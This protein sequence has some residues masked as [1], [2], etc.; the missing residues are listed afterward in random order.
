VRVLF[1]TTANDGHFGPLVPLARAFASAGHDV[2]VAAPKS[3]EAT[4]TRAGLTHRPFADAPPE[5]IGPVMARLPT[6][7]FHEADN[8]V[9][10][11]VFGRID[12]QAALPGVTAAIEE[13][14][15]DLLLREPA[16]FGSLAAAERAG[17]PHLQVAVGMAEVG[18]LIAASVAEPLAELGALAGVH[19]GSLA[20]AALAEPTLTSVPE[21]LD[22]AGDD[23]DP[24]SAL[25]RF[26]DESPPVTTE[27]LPEWGD[28]AAP[29]VYVTFGSVAGSLPP[30]SGSYRAAL[31]A[32]ADLPIRV[33]MTLGRR[34]DPA[35]LGP[36]ARNARA[37]AWW[38][39]SA[40]LAQA[41]A[42][43][44]HGGFGTTMGALAA[45]LP[46]V[47][48]PLFTFDQRINARHVAAVGAGMGFEPGPTAIADA[49]AALLPLLAEPWYTVRA[50]AVAASIAQ[51]PP[52]AAA[53]D[54]ALNFIA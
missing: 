30:F 33:F 54:A 52:P 5:L 28:P 40:V 29:L 37:V 11:E 41:S 12:A 39:Q 14:R 21:D 4:V 7:S 31:E 46:Q 19:D 2:A 42:V 3:F 32:T 15:P 25:F 22:R 8:L 9:V 17:V 44:G 24:S 1:A 16:E 27:P 53:V 18:R 38:P 36:L 10:R 23:R 13:W 43:W 47:V 6:L 34:L 50:K 26:R 49:A 51:L 48:T 45:G 35:G 20:D